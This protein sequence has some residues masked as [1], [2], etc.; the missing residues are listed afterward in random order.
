MTNLLESSDDWTSILDTST[1]V[2]IVFLDLHKAFDFVPHKQLLMKLSAYGIQGKI[3]TWLSKFLGGRLIVLNQATS[4]W[5]P[6]ISGV[7]QGSVLGPL[8]FLLYVIDISDLVLSNLKM[9]AD[10]A[11]NC[12]FL[13]SCHPPA[14]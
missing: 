7:P 12:K 4:E 2:D 6:F 1:A 3:A 9:F 10:E 11:T 13:V 14:W 8:L 5:T